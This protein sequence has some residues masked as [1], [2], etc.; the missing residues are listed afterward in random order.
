M[1][2]AGILA[3]G[4][5]SRM[6]NAVMPK[7]FLRVA[8]V[9]IFIRTLSTFLS[10]EKIDK[11]VVSMN[12]DWKDKYFELIDE[13]GI[14][15]DKVILVPGGDTRFLSLR[16]IVKGAYDCCPDG[17]SVIVTHDCARLFV[18]AEIIENNIKALEKFRIAT[19]SLPVIDT[20]IASDDGESIA[21]VP[22]R[23][24]LW[25]DQGPQSF[26][27]EEFLRYADKL[28]EEETAAL[29][30][31]GALYLKNNIKVGIVPGS[32]YNFKV[33]NDFDLKYSEFLIREGY[34]K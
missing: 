28:T 24:R 3:G 11:A 16:N 6:E 29:I 25:N 8:G 1:I 33:T 21:D 31:A 17:S 12:M 20:V 9:P 2:F 22:V 30:E 23:S 34:V 19:T 13:F 4:T 27:C 7:Q 10:V 18:T 32:R 26:Y 15:K 14:D 5:G